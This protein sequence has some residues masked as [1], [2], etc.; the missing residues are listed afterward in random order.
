M[1]GVVNRCDYRKHVTPAALESC[2]DANEEHSSGFDDSCDAHA[3]KPFADPLD[4]T[5]GMC[6]TV[7]RFADPDSVPPSI[8]NGGSPP[9]PS[10]SPPP[11]PPPST[12]PAPPPSLSPS[13]V[14]SPSASPPSPSP[15]QSCTV[16]KWRAC[17]QNWGGVDLGCCDPEDDTVCYRQSAHYS[18][19][20]PRG[21]CPGNFEGC[22]DGEPAGSPPPTPPTPPPPPP[23]PSPGSLTCEV[24]TWRS[25]GGVGACCASPNDTCFVKDRW[26][27]QCRPDCP[28]GQGW[29]CERR[30]RRL[31][32]SKA[33]ATSNVNLPGSTFLDRQEPPASSR[34]AVWGL[35]GAGLLLLPLLAAR[36]RGKEAADEA[37]LDLEESQ[38]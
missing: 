22:D 35:A 32:E 4:T 10:P 8:A 13:P 16:Q 9:P 25:C 5:P 17:G 24:Q 26:Y 36:R 15:S 1:E 23:P 38:A 6:W 3:D 21:D 19:C 11:P 2:R 14:R 34:P 28:L 29:E 20:R 30:Q 27:S 33:A 37:A 7:T 12:S 18:Q 31:R